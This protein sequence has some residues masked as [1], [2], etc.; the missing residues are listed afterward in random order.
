MKGSLRVALL[1]FTAL[2]VQRWL[3]AGGTVMVAAVYLLLPQEARVLTLVGL[4]LGLFPTLLASGVLLRY[5]AAPR[6]MQLIPHVRLQ[7]LGAMLLL[8]LIFATTFAAIA[9][10]VF[11]AGDYLLIWLRV[12]AA[13]SLLLISQFMLFGTAAGAAL[14]FSLVIVAFAVPSATGSWEFYLW[15]GQRPEMLIAVLAVVWCGFSIWLLR[16]RP[17]AAPRVSNMVA[18]GTQVVRASQNNA[19]RAFLFGNPSLP[20]QF[21]AGLLAVV[22]ITLM[23]SLIAGINGRAH[24]FVD[25]IT[26]ASWLAMGVGAYAGIGGWLVARR[27]KFLWLRCGLDRRDLFRLCEREAWNSFVATASG[28]F[29]LLPI[30][31]LMDASNGPE[32]TLL[33]V[34]QLCSGACLLYLGLTWVRG[35]RTIDVLGGLALF[36]AWFTASVNSPYLAEHL[37]IALALIA[38]LLAV[39]LVLRL[40][41]LYR[42]RRIDWL[43]C[44][45]P[46]PLARNEMNPA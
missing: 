30:L 31:W 5:I 2:P 44:K 26:R 17:L 39:A 1:L 36:I 33:L 28:T 7:I 32:Y 19:V 29:L 46:P 16:P 24:S 14:W 37:P 27:S 11:P 34:I 23:F 18:L 21:V 10:S 43:V 9:L 25:V 12:A 6:V 42:W 3:L 38:A 15:I 22:F 8:P 20:A 41:G 13:V 4:V 45:P 35:W 40:L